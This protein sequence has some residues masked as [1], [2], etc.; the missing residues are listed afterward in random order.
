MAQAAADDG[1]PRSVFRTATGEL[2]DGGANC[3]MTGQDENW[4][5]LKLNGA[6]APV[7]K[8]LVSAGDVVR[9]GHMVLLM[10]DESFVIYKG[11]DIMKDVRWLIKRSL[12]VHRRKGVP[13]IYCEKGVFNFY[14]HASGTNASSKALC[15]QDRTTT[16]AYSSS[17]GGRRQGQNP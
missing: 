3:Y 1:K 14:V 10:D 4:T 9:K 2:V 12:M 6:S 13:P 17:S 15:N 16:T 5:S 7:H 11:T 8:V